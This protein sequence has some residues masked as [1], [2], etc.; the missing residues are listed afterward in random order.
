MT[1]LLLLRSVPFNI[2][3]RL[4]LM[5]ANFLIHVWGRTSL[6]VRLPNLN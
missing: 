4:Q 6:Y 2:H 3:R 5:P 1:Y